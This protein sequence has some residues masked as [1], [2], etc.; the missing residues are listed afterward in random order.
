MEGKERKERD[1]GTALR[2]GSASNALHI[3]TATRKQ[4]EDG[5]DGEL[6]VLKEE[7]GGLEAEGEGEGGGEIRALEVYGRKFGEIVGR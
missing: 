7:G 2:A 1:E 6:R 4:R 3:I 5:R